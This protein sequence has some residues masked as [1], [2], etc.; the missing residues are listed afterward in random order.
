MADY[1]SFTRTNYFRVTDEA[2]YQA[3]Y[4][5]LRAENEALYDFTTEKDGTIWHSFGMYGTID[6]S[7]D[8][9][10]MDGWFHKLQKLLPEDEA[11]ILLEVG[12]EK[13]RY[14]V[15]EYTVV[16]KNAIENG[17]IED[18]SINTARRLLHDPSLKTKIEY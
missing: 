3:L 18:A 1:I 14:L 8:E 7:E 6:M 13:L 16:T 2:A 15:G 10:G 17:N 12:H 11:A 9:D 5:Y 4:S